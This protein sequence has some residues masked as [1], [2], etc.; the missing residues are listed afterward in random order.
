MPDWLSVVD[1]KCRVRSKFVS[2]KIDQ[3]EGTALD[4]A[5]G[6]QQHLHDDRWFHGTEAFYKVTAEMAG[7]FRETIG[8]TEHGYSG[9]LG[10]I[11][12][13]LLLDA[14]LIEQHRE[15]LDQFYQ[16]LSSINRSHVQSVVSELATRPADNL[17]HW[18]D[19]FIRERFLEDYLDD[20]RLLTR[21]NQVMKRVSLPKLPPQ[22][23]Q[24]LQ[25]GRELV[26]NQVFQLLPQQ[27]F[28]EQS[29]LRPPSSSQ[30][31]A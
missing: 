1:R 13:E 23:V 31:P 20:E 25:F 6:I 11:V 16:A 26:R 24:T 18:I 4:I 5:L 28:P 15:Q 17:A 9:F 2:Q 27:H 7:S 22:T 12:M 29:V 14:A 10:H 3:L 8:T 19:L 21:L 30:P